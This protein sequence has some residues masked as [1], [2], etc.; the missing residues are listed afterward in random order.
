MNIVKVVRVGRLAGTAILVLASVSCG[1]MA[2][3]GRAPSYLVITSLQGSSGAED[4]LGGELRS[5]V[6]TV[7]EDVA[8]TFND[9][10]EVEFQLAMKDPTL[11]EP[12]SANFITID[13]YHV[14]YIRADGRNTQGVDVPY[15]FDGAITGTVADEASF[16]FTLVRHQAKDEAP[17]R[18][19]AINGTIISTIAEVTFYGHD[20][21]GRAVS[22]TGR[23]SVHFGNFGDPE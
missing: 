3:E 18:A 10:G 15:E 1:E 9:N 17:L 13:R 19:L 22:V 7:V 4:E 2:R 20:Q 5:D 21:T 12:S 6:I 8:T 16:G 14:R 23:I 11:T